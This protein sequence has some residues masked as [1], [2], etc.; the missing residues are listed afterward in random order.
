MIDSEAFEDT[1]AACCAHVGSTMR[2]SKLSGDGAYSFDP[3][4]GLFVDLD[5]SLSMEL[6]SN[7]GQ[8]RLNLMVNSTG[9]VI[10]CSDDSNHS[11]PGYDACPAPLVEIVE[12]N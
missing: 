2:S 9:R 3:I 4:R 10:L 5:D 6:H 11:I 1:A 12:V 7:N 8:Y